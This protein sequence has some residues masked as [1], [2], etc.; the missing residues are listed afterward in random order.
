MKT[1]V[2]VLLV[3]CSFPAFADGQTADFTPTT[4]VLPGSEFGIKSGDVV[5]EIN[6][7]PVKDQL[8]AK[9]RLLRDKASISQIKV[10]RKGKL[11][12]LTKR[13]QT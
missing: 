11:I 7:Q 2:I 4:I 8:E 9:Q 10:L 12:K 5:K 1:L 3:L 6:D 13:P